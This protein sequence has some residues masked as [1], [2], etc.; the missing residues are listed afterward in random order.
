MKLLRISGVAVLS[1]LIAFGCK[2]PSEGYLSKVLVY[3]P[4]TLNAVKG[5][6]TTSAALLVDGSTNP[7]NVKLLAVRNYYTK[8]PADSILLK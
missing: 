5:R 2:K 3:N 7:I 4:K 8:Q 6:V 1:L